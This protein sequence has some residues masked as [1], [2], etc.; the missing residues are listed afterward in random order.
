MPE[1]FEE[2]LE[3]V[4]EMIKDIQES[5]GAAGSSPVIFLLTSVLATAMRYIA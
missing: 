3:E 1:V 2:F 4:P 5:S